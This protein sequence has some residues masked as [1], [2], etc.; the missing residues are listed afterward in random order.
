[1]AGD[2]NLLYCPYY[3]GKQFEL[4]TVRETAALMAERGA[5]PIIAPVREQARGLVRA[6]TAV[7]DSDGQAII[8]LNPE[9]G[10]LRDNPKRVLEL[11]S[12]CDTHSGLV[13]GIRLGSDA[14]PS[15]VRDIISL[16]DGRDV[17]IIHAGVASQ[18]ALELCRVV[19]KLVF[20]VFLHDDCGRLYR[21][22][23]VDEATESVR[24]VLIKNGFHKKKNRDY[25]EEELF[26]DLHVLY[27]DLG[28]K[29]STS[30]FGDFSIAG[31]QYS[32]SGGPAY[33][34]AIHLTY[35][36]PS[37]ENAMFVRHF[38]S[39][40]MDSPQDPGGKFLEAARKLVKFLE[41]KQGE[42]VKRTEPIEEF[43][44]LFKKEH[45]P[46]LGYVKKMSMRHHVETILG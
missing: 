34:V 33:A 8:I 16:C 1:M 40:R 20:H 23:I 43:K 44:E 35:K 3:R 31:D 30:G 5:V 45:F 4:I 18:R 2:D 37:R 7:H 38:V 22:A 10:E 21:R 36:D 29:D 28:P 9:V 14:A 17:A 6:L 25:P 24:T 12:A 15:R 27:N 41:S 39:D 19:N 46:G 13:Y 11:V 32:E 42:K 26:S